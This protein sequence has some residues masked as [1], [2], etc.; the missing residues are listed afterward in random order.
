M[1]IPMAKPATS[2]KNKTGSWRLMKP[3]FEEGKCVKCGICQLYC[4]ELAINGLER[5]PRDLPSFN[6][7]YCKGCGI[8]A[9]VC[10]MKAIKM[11]R[12]KK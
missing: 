3:V 6:M 4:P 7:D 12:E 1:R 11:I 9:S 2:M 10:P 5:N 8:C